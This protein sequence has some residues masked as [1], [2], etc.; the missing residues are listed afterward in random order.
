GQQQGPGAARHRHAHGAATLSPQA[1]SVISRQWS[2]RAGLV[3]ARNRRLDISEGL[4][5]SRRGDSEVI[6]ESAGWPIPES[7]GGL[8]GAQWLAGRIRSVSK[9]ETGEP[10]AGNS[11]RWLDERREGRR[12]LDRSG[13]FAARPRPAISGRVCR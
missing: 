9:P 4:L 7:A 2:L 13:A 10:S 12:S 6:L 8:H 5:F 1:D 3:V 11:L